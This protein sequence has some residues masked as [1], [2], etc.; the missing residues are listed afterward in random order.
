MQR[1]DAG[2]TALQRDF[3]REYVE[4]GGEPRLAKLA[5]CRAGVEHWRTSG[6]VSRLLGSAKVL[7]AIPLYRAARS[8]PDAPLA[9]EVIATL[10]RV[11][12]SPL[13]SPRD[14]LA[15][16]AKLADV[17]GV[18]YDASAKVRLLEAQAEAANAALPS[19]E[20]GAALVLP[21]TVDAWAVEEVGQ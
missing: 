20:V 14:Q 12:R 3:V 5:A 4:L 8:K 21:P 11:M 2:L 9:E 19:G 13:S 7:A 17:L 16:A 6:A 1:W 15:A 10:A 18:S